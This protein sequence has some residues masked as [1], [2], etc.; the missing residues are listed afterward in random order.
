MNNVLEEHAK[1]M[2]NEKDDQFVLSKKHWRLIDEIIMQL[3]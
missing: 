2:G 1:P 3:T